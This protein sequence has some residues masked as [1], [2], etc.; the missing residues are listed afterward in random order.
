MVVYALEQR[1]EILRHYFENHGNAA[2][3]RMCAKIAY[4]FW[5]KR[6]TVSS[7]CPLSCERTEETGI[8]IDKPKRT[9]EYIATMTETVREASS[10]SIDCRSQQLNIWE[11]SMRRIL[12]KALLQSM[13]I[14]IRP[15]VKRIFI[16][17]K[18]RRI[19]STF[20]AEA[21]LDALGPVFEDFIIS[22]RA[23]VNCIENRLDWL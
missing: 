17:K 5:K 20:E 13:A 21:T 11:I 9:L 8:L 10:T 6:S 18:W 4:G 2:E 3:C 14:V 19:L 22:R 15:C 23:I 1:W 7:V 12:H 16:H